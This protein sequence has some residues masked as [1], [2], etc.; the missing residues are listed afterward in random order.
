MRTLRET[1]IW[2]SKFVKEARRR[3]GG[4]VYANPSPSLCLFYFILRRS[5]ASAVLWVKPKIEYARR[6]RARRKGTKGLQVY[7]TP[8][9]L[10]SF[11]PFLTIA[12]TPSLPHTAIGIAHAA[13]LGNLYLPH[14]RLILAVT[15]SHSFD[16]MVGEPVAYVQ[17]LPK[18][19]GCCLVRCTNSPITIGSE[20]PK[21][22]GGAPLV[23][24]LGKRRHANG[25]QT[26]IERYS[27]A[28]QI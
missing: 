18:G 20:G 12:S 5:S 10:L 13:V 25:Q 27:A 22:G 3:G 19:H 1:K 17:G 21:T 8:L 6:W 23:F 4:E 16:L 24:P 26:F 28:E 9:R 15:V 7:A 14:K 2:G 11:V